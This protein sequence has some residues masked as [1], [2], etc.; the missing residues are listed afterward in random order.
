MN[1]IKVFPVRVSAG[2]YVDEVLGELK[3]L[4]PIKLKEISTDDL[5]KDASS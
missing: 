2:N 4:N 1:P 3:L 5:F